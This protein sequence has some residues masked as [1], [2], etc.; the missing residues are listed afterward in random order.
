MSREVSYPLPEH[1]MVKHRVG[2]RGGVGLYED[3]VVQRAHSPAVAK[4]VKNAARRVQAGRWTGGPS[5]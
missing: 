2:R 5:L 4:A 1:R 3:R